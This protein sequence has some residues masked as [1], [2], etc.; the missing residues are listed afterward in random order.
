[1]CQLKAIKAGRTEN[2][3]L[4]YKKELVKML[5]NKGFAREEIL[6]IGRFLD[7]IFLMSK[8]AKIEY[9]LFIDTIEQEKH[10]SYM[11]TFEEV[12][13]EKGIEKGEKTVLLRQLQLKFKTV[14]DRYLN[15]I[16]MA[17]SETII[18]WADRILFCN[19]IEEI[20]ID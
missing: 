2:K 16:N 13:F 3:K 14:S 11:T 4:Y 19:K 10:M 1:M 7:G 18:K 6:N 9:N 5:Y 17:N 8:E 15:M 12:G 20:F